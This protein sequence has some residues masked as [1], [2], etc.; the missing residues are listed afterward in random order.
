VSRPHECVNPEVRIG[1]DEDGLG[2]LRPGDLVLAPCPVCGETPFDAMQDLQRRLDETQAALTNHR[3]DTPLYHWSP[4]AKRGQINRSGLLPG[5]RTTTST[6]DD[7]FRGAAVCL[8]DSPSWAWAL[9]GGMPWTP[10][11]SWDLWETRLELLTDPVVLA[12]QDR[13]SGLY[14]VRTEHRVWKRDVWLAG[15]RW[16]DL[17]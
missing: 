7:G 5:R 17:P 10:A 9:S 6:A 4:T 3:A 11:G 2:D 16:K 14:E 8:A 15:Q 13:A 1:D 12:S